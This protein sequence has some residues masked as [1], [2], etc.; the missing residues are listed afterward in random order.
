MTK[1][2]EA[3]TRTRSR[4]RR[5]PSPSSAGG[6]AAPQKTVTIG[7]AYDGVGA[8][9]PYRRAGA[10]D[11]EVA[12][13][14]HQ[15]DELD[16]AAAPH[17]QH[18]G[19]Q[20]GDRE[21]LRAQAPRAGR[22]RD[23]DDVRRR[24]RRA[25]RAGLDQPREAD[26]RGVHRHRPDGAEALRPE[27]STRVLVRQRCPGRG[28][29]HGRVRMEARVAERVARDRHGHRLLPQRRPGVRGPLHATRRRRS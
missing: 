27:G 5:L 11:S 1:F 9:A 18:A 14:R 8:M 15:Q 28:L 3:T 21:G 23:H 26:G 25:C 4:S 24:L 22:R 16:E 10:R 29:G 20:A 2:G 7:W 6:S 12:H 13:R 19:Q 17:V